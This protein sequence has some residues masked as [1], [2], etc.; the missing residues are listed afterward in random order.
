MF[1][2]FLLEFPKL[3]K[4]LLLQDEPENV[5]CNQITGEWNCSAKALALVLGAEGQ[6]TKQ[7]AEKHKASSCTAPGPRLNFSLA[8]LLFALGLH[9]TWA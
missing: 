1:F 4:K 8:G 9:L 5:F 7:T 3:H 6:I 2:L